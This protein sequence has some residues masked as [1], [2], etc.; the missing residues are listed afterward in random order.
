[1]AAAVVMKLKFYSV[2]YIKGMWHK[3]EQNHKVTAPKNA[4]L[5]TVFKL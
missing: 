3:D 2:T 5:I 1:M 4:Y